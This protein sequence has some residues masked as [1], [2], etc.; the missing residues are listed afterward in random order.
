MDP[1]TRELWAPLAYCQG[2]S[3]GT[4]S[5]SASE[6]CWQRGPS[7]RLGSWR[8]RM[9]AGEFLFHVSSADYICLY[10]SYY[11]QCTISSHFNRLSEVKTSRLQIILHLLPFKWVVSWCHRLSHPHLISNCL[12]ITLRVALGQISCWSFPWAQ[13]LIIFRPENW[14]KGKAMEIEIRLTQDGAS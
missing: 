1:Q 12:Y 9:R 10:L 2:A 11:Y 8:L 5:D 3:W 7:N 13:I 6:A 4:G 14:S